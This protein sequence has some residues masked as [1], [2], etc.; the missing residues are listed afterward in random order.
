[1]MNRRA[2]V[3]STCAGVM[4]LSAVPSRAAQAKTIT[5][6]LAA[7]ADGNSLKLFNRTATRLVDGARKGVRLGVAEGEGMAFLPAIELANGTIEFDLRG[8]DVVPQQSF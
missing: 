3:I 6:D 5:P 8:R 7:L 1:M 2:F 4:G